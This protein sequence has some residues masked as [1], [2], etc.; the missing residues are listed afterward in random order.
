MSAIRQ[1]ATVIGEPKHGV[2]RVQDNGMVRCWRRYGMVGL[3]MNVDPNGN[4]D[5]HQMDIVMN[6]YDAY[7]PEE[8]FQAYKYPHQQFG[9]GYHN[10]V[11]LT[12]YHPKFGDK[13]HDHEPID[14]AH[15]YCTMSQAG[16]P[17]MMD[18]WKYAMGQPQANKLG[19]LAIR[20]GRFIWISMI[21]RN[22]I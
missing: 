1:T 10:F 18:V 9:D 7:I 16:F 6:N 20:A 17:H 14:L 21:Y 11:D 22:Q 4:L 2:W 5:Q 3:D 15:F 8:G 19:P 12:I 13:Y